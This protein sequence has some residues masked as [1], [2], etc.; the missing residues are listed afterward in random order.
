[1]EIYSHLVEISGALLLIL[2]LYKL[3]WLIDHRHRGKSVLPPEPRVAL[4]I[5][6][7]LHLLGAE[8]TFARTLA[9]IAD[10]CG[11]IFMIWL[12][13]HRTVVVSNSETV[14]ECFTTN[15]RVL[16]SRPRSS[17]GKYLSYNYAAFGFLPA[18]AFWSHIRKLVMIQLLS[19]HRLKSLRHVQVSEVNSLIQDWYL[20]CDSNQGQAKVVIS[21]SLDRLT[22]NMITRMIA[23][24]RY[25]GSYVAG[26]EGEGKRIGE[27]IKEYLY[28]SG[29]LVPS[30]LIPFL[31]WM[32]YFTGPVKVMKRLSRELDDLMDSWIE[33]HKLKRLKN[34]DTDN[35]ED[36]IDVMLSAIEDDCIFGHSRETIIKGTIS[37]LIVAGAETT[38]IALT[39]MLANLLNSRH[40]LEK[41]Q[42]ELDLEV[43]RE[44]LVEDSDI[45]NLKYLQAVV[46]ETLRL[47]P[48]GPTA[49]PHEAIEDCYIGGYHI[50]KGTRVFANLWKLHR[51]PNIWSNPDKFMPERFLTEETGAVDVFGQH[52][53]LIPF[54]SGRRSCPG[55]TFALQVLHLALARI[56]QG[57]SITTPMNKA[58]SMTEGLGITLVKATPLEAQIVPRL[59]A[60]F[61]EC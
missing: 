24:K 20:L 26:N 21:E 30:D 12:G 14:K 9:A 48:P 32:N 6:G 36:F 28:I 54:G 41:V 57:F 58:V 56:L 10:R 46:K 45:S 18:N 11:P 33:E 19:S 51:D 55:I 27:L 15:D 47:Y 34:Q 23:G 44:R 17:H 31:G 29:V 37:T 7:H 35:R 1:M 61:Y 53:E 13:V 42:E 3:R 43:G 52:F 22:I 16:A 38:S 59:G 50:P 2:F 49:V 8:R 40:T 5:I 60:R 25:F 4:P 39:W